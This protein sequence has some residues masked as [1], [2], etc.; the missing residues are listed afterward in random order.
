MIQ[1]RLHLRPLG[2]RG[3][4]LGFA[5]FS[6]GLGGISAAH[7]RPAFCRNPVRQQPTRRWESSIH[8]DKKS[9]HISSAPNESILFF[10]SR[11]LFGGATSTRE[12]TSDRSVSAKNHITPALASMGY[13]PG[14]FCDP[15]E[16]G[17]SLA[18]P[19][20]PC[21]LGE[22]GHLKQGAHRSH[23][24][25]PSPEGWRRLCQIYPLQRRIIHGDRRCATPAAAQR[26]WHCQSLC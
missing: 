12:L 4:P 19:P 7:S 13:L 6:P 5:S 18:G 8:D 14:P 10:D 2:R 3:L 20:R 9:G 26:P 16:A 25:H 17:K 21:E 22:T 11:P 1:G 24:D 15:Q 23:R